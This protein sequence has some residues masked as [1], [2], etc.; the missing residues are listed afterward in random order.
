[1]Y[2]L[3]ATS[4]AQEKMKMLRTLVL[5]VIKYYSLTSLEITTQKCAEFCFVYYN[6]II[7]IKADDGDHCSSNPCKN[8]GT[9]IEEEDGYRCKCSHDWYSGKN[10][11][12][13]K[14]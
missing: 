2:D 3:H 8:E 7:K 13:G 11:E 4:D 1:M 10:C 14:L 6:F 12:K 9:C 5:L